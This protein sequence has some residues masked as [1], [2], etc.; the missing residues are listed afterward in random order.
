M[1]NFIRILIFCDGYRK[2]CDGYRKFCDGY[3]KFCDGVKLQDTEIYQSFEN[4]KNNNEIRV[5]IQ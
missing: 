5:I 2:F 1:D 4:K 3:R